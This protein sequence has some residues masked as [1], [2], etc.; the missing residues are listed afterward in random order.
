MHHL[1]SLLPNTRPTAEQTLLSQLQQALAGVASPD[2]TKAGDCKNGRGNHCC[3][4]VLDEQVQTAIDDIQPPVS[5][6]PIE[7]VK[8]D[9]RV[10]YVDHPQSNTERL[11]KMNLFCEVRLTLPSHKYVEKR[12][13]ESVLMECTDPYYAASGYVKDAE[14]GIYEYVTA[15]CEDT[16]E[17]HL[18]TLLGSSQSSGA[19]NQFVRYFGHSEIVLFDSV[20]VTSQVQVC[21]DTSL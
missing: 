2:L 9:Y 16:S 1:K 19:I 18:N 11:R 12:F 7:I 10:Y 17:E 3:R 14:T 20:T 15:N 8:A 21:F 6:S 13:G 4:M 5:R